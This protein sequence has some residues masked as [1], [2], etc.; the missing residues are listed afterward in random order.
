[1]QK[2]A[3]QLILSGELT[4]FNSSQEIPHF[5]SMHVI[6]TVSSKGEKTFMTKSCTKEGEVLVGHSTARSG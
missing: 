1:M 6:S 3:R 2:A 4:S 5:F